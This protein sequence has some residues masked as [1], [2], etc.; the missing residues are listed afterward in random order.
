MRGGFQ[1]P[2]LVLEPAH[3][4]GNGSRSPS[5]YQAN[6]TAAEL[7]SENDKAEVANLITEYK[8]NANIRNKIR[9]NTLD[10]AGYGADEDGKDEGKASLH[11][12]A[13]DG[14]IN[15]V[16][17]LLERGIDINSR[18]PYD[19]NRT[20]LDRAAHK[21][22][23]DL[24]RLLIER[25][26]EVDARD[27]W[28]WTPLH[29]ASDSG[30]LEVSRVLIDHG[31]N[32]NARHRDHWTPMHISAYLGHLELVKLILECG[33]DVHAPNSHGQTPY[34]TLLTSGHREA[35]DLLWEHGVGRAR[36]EKILL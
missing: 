27:D 34:Q 32:V 17:A 7:A 28:G 35:A 11:A 3:G 25:G 29:C 21:G 30:H 33:A 20:P 1:S 23:V 16:K 6:K 22:N 36:F 15:V 2:C 24:V 31:A 12:A 18:N 14:N 10:T 19:H 5:H 9:S 4:G 26:A 13:E 8:T